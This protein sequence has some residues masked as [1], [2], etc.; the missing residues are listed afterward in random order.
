MNLFAWMTKWWKHQ[1]EFA[2]NVEG[3]LNQNAH[4]KQHV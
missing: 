4:I 3:C 2:I 1:C